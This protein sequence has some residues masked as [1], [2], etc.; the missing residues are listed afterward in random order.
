[1]FQLRNIRT[2]NPFTQMGVM[3]QNGQRQVRYWLGMPEQPRESKE[4]GGKPKTTFRDWYDSLPWRRGKS[5]RREKVSLTAQFSQIHLVNQQTQIPTVVHIGTMIGRSASDVIVEST[6]HRPVRL[7]FAQIDPEQFKAPMRLTYLAGEAK[8]TVD[9]VEVERETTIKERAAIQID[10]QSYECQLYAWDKRA[11]VTR[12]DAGWATIRGKRADN[13]DAIGIY[14]HSKAY[15]FA[16]ADG[17][18]SGQYGQLISEFAIQYL[19]ASFDK[20][21]RYTL[22][23]HDILKKAFN[24][25]NAEVRYFGRRSPNVEGSTLTAVVIKDWEAYVTH[26]GDTR[27]YL[28]HDGEMRQLT[29]DHTEKRPVIERDTRY[30]AEMDAAPKTQDVLL[31]AIGKQDGIAPDA[32]TVSLQP[33]DR[34]LLCSDGLTKCLSL[35]EIRHTLTTVRSTRAADELMKQAN[36]RHPD[37]NVSAV[38]LEVLREPY[39]KD[40][41]EAYNSERVYA[42][43]SRMWSLRLKKPRENYTVHPAIKQPNFYARL[44]LILSLLLIIPAFNWYRTAVLGMV[45]VPTATSTATPTADPVIEM[46]MTQQI[47]SPTPF[48]PTATATATATPLPT[49]TATPTLTLTPTPIPP[50]STLRVG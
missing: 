44:A 11:I 30:A 25:I 13:E 28:W 20:N 45:D 8:L 36:E 26:V 50:T 49:I 16:V 38:T 46:E 4:R 31:K 19:L 32:F 34:L 48:V 5:W 42:G 41:W 9:G 1:M 29:T 7:R 10:D 18:G 24:Y 47:I 22:P 39:V 23:W 35:D 2:N 43:Y 6:S 12:V 33:G 3:F 21:I 14:Q 15:L 27:L 37:D 40:L 17:V